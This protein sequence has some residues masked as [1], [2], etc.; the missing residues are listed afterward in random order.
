VTETRWTYIAAAPSKTVQAWRCAFGGFSEFAATSIH[1]LE[2][3]A[4]TSVIVL[5]CGEPVTLRPALRPGSAARLS[6]FDALG[7][8]RQHRRASR[9][10][11]PESYDPRSPGDDERTTPEDFMQGNVSFV[12]LGSSDTGRSRPAG[13]EADPPASEEPGFGRFSSCRDPQGIRFGLH[14]HSAD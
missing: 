13:G 3:P 14:Q 11:R 4:A 2:P 12:E 10:Q 9:I 7:R 8:P 5:C 6:S 1:R